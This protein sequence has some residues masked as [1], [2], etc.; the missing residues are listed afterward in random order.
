V[1]LDLI[2]SDLLGGIEVQKTFS[3]NL[4]GEFGGGL[5]N[6]TT[7]RRPDEPFSASRPVRPTTEAS[8][9]DGLTHY[10]ED[11]DWT[12]YERRSARPAERLADLIASGDALNTQS[13]DF[14]E[15]VAKAW[16]IRR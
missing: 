4:P 9:E 15:G 13:D 14:I 16:S 8:L 2:P 6:M 7:V 3:A 5:I 11:S 10:G 1:P 12:G